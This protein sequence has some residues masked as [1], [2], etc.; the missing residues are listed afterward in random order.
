MAAAGTERDQVRKWV[1]HYA[2]LFI[3]K[4]ELFVSQ[5]YDLLITLY[6]DSNFAYYSKLKA[7]KR[8]WENVLQLRDSVILLAFHLMS[9]TPYSY[10]ESY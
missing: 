7:W 10:S 3:N 4:Y 2:E 5:S 9:Y 8:N 6:Y 1:T